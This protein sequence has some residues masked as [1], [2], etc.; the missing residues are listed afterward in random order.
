MTGK[1]EDGFET[2]VHGSTTKECIYKLMDDYE[3]E[4]GELVYYLGHN[5]KTKEYVEGEAI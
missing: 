4:H 5:A 2:E 1:F 3:D